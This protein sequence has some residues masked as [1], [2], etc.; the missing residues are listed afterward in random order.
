ML[1]DTET[2]VR[3]SADQTRLRILSATRELY[4]RNGSRGTTTREVAERAGVNEATLFRHFG[5]KQGL[6]EAMREHFCEIASLR[7]VADAQQGPL[8]Q[9]L[10]T[11]GL[12]I[13]EHMEQNK[14][15]IFVTLAEVATDPEG[16]ALMWRIPRAKL[17]V[18]TEFFRSRIDAGELRGN[19]EDLAHLFMGP[20]FAYVIGQRV[21]ATECFS[22]ERIVRTLVD[23]FLNGVRVRR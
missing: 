17:A 21:W 2:P 18:M 3:T 13:V 20:L 1:K 12:T 10:V 15:L 14:D 23:I 6:L 19:P 22:R 9:S 7:E 4:A 5:T 8:E 16:A 11:L